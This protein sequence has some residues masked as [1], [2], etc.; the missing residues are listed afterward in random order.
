MNVEE[1][2]NGLLSW[3]LRDQEVFVRGI[4]DHLA[5]DADPGGVP[6]ILLLHDE[7]ELASLISLVCSE[8]PNGKAKFS[9]ELCGRG[10]IPS[11]F[12]SG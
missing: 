12:P 3:G 5:F 1:K 7:L 9:R 2:R 11:F 10:G 6:A 4:I 8:I